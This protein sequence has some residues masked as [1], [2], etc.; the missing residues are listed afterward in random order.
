MKKLILLTL[1]ATATGL[2]FGQ[3]AKFNDGMTK[4][5]SQFDTAKSQQGLMNVSN[6]FER[7]ANAEKNQWLPYYYAAFTRV[8]MA[9]GGDPATID[10]TLDGAEKLLNKADS[11]QPQNSEIMVVRSM[12]L[13]GRV[14]V[15]PMSRGQVFGM[16]SMIFLQQAM[17]ADPNNPRAYFVLGQS[18]FY[19]P[20]QFG[21]G[22]EAG[23]KQMQT[24]I[25]KYATFTPAS[26]LHPNWG[27][28][29]AEEMMAQCSS[30]AE[31]QVDPVTGNDK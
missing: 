30:P 18:L 23:C 24:A 19:T 21:G 10:A 11:L 16:Q 17:A 26:A 13:G 25:E 7:I 5:L 1:F 14:M 22:K 4:A 20:E 3:S 8:L 27:K 28:K 12:L 15:D 29:E 6:T 2:T 31:K 9:Y